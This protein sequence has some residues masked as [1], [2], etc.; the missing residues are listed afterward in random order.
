VHAS[1]LPL[2][3]P[4]C[5]CVLVPLLSVIVLQLPPSITDTNLVGLDSGLQAHYY[6]FA[7]ELVVSTANSWLCHLSRRYL[8]LLDMPVPHLNSRQH[9]DVDHMMQN[10][11]H[12]PELFS[13]YLT[14]FEEMSELKEKY[15]S[16]IRFLILDTLE[17]ANN[18]W[19]GRT[20]N[21]GPRRIDEIHKDAAIE[22][23][24]AKARSY[25]RGGYNDRHGHCGHGHGGPPR[26]PTMDIRVN[27]RPMNVSTLPS[28]SVTGGRPG[29]MRRNA[30][31]AANERG[32]AGREQYGGRGGN[33]GSA[34]WSQHHPSGSRD[35]T[36]GPQPHPP[37]MPP[38]PDSKAS[39][40]A[41]EVDAPVVV[42]F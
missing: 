25:T 23:Q 4:I 11:K 15:D 39:R 40:P 32:N 7:I 28:G 19:Q 5:R 38:A 12:N 20:K 9:N 21:E 6:V 36:L 1:C 3:G 16:R 31:S 8:F 27:P 34:F 24:K 18:Q 10:S 22:E 29:G 2:Q 33:S 41:A 42:R 17:L 35:E 14:R 30:H 37:R 26:P 13:L